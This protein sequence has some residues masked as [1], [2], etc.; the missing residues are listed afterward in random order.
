MHRS[1]HHLYQHSYGWVGMSSAHTN[2]NYYAPKRMERP[3]AVY[4][5]V[6]ILDMLLIAGHGGVQGTALCRM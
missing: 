6:Q 2:Q 1:L 3:A 4:V 5:H